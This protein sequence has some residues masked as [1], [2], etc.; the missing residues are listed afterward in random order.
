M[1]IQ[2]VGIADIPEIT[3]IYNEGVEDRIATYLTEPQTVAAR[4]AWFLML[5]KRCKVLASFDDTGRMTGWAS[6]NPVKHSTAPHVF[7]HVSNISVYVERAGRGKGV[8]KALLEALDTAAR[9]NGF[10]RLELDVFDFNEAAV[11][12]YER[13]GFTFAGIYRDRAMY[14]GKPSNV[15]F[16]E[17]ILL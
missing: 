11:R 14:E 9:E 16:M 17:K 8:G 6:L 7:D 10:T 4:T 12:L 2:E 1:Q 13:A 3:R 5:P 15:V